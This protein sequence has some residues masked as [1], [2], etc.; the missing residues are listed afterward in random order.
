MDV[1]ISGFGVSAHDEMLDGARSELPGLIGTHD[2]ANPS[3]IL[4][5]L[6]RL[7]QFAAVV[8]DADRLPLPDAV[9]ELVGDL[10]EHTRS[11]RASAHRQ[12][13]IADRRALAQIESLQRFQLQLAQLF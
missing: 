12:H 3:A 5:P 2:L 8:D 10:S 13:D 7:D 4:H 9:E 1:R 11:K 6:E